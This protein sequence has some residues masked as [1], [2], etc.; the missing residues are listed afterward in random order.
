MEDPPLHRRWKIWEMWSQNKEHSA[1]FVSNMQEVGEFSSVFTFWQHW[2]Y[3]PH[4][5]P[6]RLFED[7]ETKVKVLVEGLNQSIEAIGVFVDGV[8]PAWEDPVNEKGCD[9]CVRKYSGD[10]RKLKEGWDKLV[11]SVIGESLPYNQEI[12]GCRVVDKKQNYK[13]ELWMSTDL[14]QADVGKVSEIKNTFANLMSGHPPNVSVA[15]HRK[16]DSP[17]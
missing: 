12:V 6:A 7:P 4:A 11:L 1:N 2:N 17:T 5:D 13:F 14:A 3:F 15:S 10:F 8:R 9:V 16:Y